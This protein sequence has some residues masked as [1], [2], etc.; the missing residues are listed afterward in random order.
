[1][2]KMLVLAAAAILLCACARQ[3]EMEAP[4]RFYYPRKELSFQAGSDV[5]YP[6]LRE[7]AGLENDLEAL[8][9]LYLAGPADGQ[10]VSPFP[11]GTRLV[12]WKIEDS[13][14]RITLSQE[15]ARL[16]GLELNIAAVCLAKTGMELTGAEAVE[17]RVEEEMLDGKS[18]LL[19][20]PEQIRL[21]DDSSSLPTETSR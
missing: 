13:V 16:S 9:R 7:S 20:T 3:P 5:L 4:V 10:S 11:A 14:L 15:F 18:S 2:K 6:E 19:L 17:L 12:D 1:M 8:L 21:L